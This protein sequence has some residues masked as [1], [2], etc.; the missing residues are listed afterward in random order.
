MS[1]SEAFSHKYSWSGGGVIIDAAVVSASRVRAVLRPMVFAR[2]WVACSVSLSLFIVS[3]VSSSKIFRMSNLGGTELRCI[4]AFG[5]FALSFSQTSRMNGMIVCGV[6]PRVTSFD[7][8]EM[9][10]SVKFAMSLGH[11][12]FGVLGVPSRNLSSGGGFPVSIIWASC[13]AVMP[14]MAQLVGP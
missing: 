3:F 11:G 4:A 5:A 8:I 12:C 13:G 9:I 6:S 1:M 7:P 10:I 14:D 2:R